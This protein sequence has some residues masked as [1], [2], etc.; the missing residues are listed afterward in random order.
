VKPAHAQVDPWS[1]VVGIGGPKVA[2]YGGNMLRS[3]CSNPQ[4]A[5]WILKGIMHGFHFKHTWWACVYADGF[6]V[7]NNFRSYRALD[8]ITPYFVG[9]C[10]GGDCDAVTDYG[11]HVCFPQMADMMVQQHGEIVDIYPEG[12]AD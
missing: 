2:Q 9:T 10:D 4:K 3:L 8:A 11:Q 7:R 12:P 6:R 5:Q 1:I